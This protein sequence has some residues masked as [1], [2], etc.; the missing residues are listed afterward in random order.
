[1]HVQHSVAAADPAP[2]PAAAAAFS[3]HSVNPLT[4][5]LKFECTA[6]SSLECV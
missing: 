3:R 4:R 5:G 2:A 6:R 1:L